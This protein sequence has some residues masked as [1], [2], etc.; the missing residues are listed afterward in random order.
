M[1]TP[2]QP[3]IMDLRCESVTVM[4]ARLRADGVKAALMEAD[5]PWK[6]SGGKNDTRRG[7][8]AQHYGGLSD[9]EIARHLAL[10]GAIAAENAYLAMWITMPK[11]WD[12]FRLDLPPNPTTD[13]I[14]AAANAYPPRCLTDAGWIGLTGAGWG[15][16]KGNGVG[17]HLRGDFEPVLIWKRAGTLPQDKSISSLTLTTETLD[18]W[19]DGCRNLW[20][21]RR[22]GHSEKPQPAL[23]S[24]L[25]MAT[26]PGDTVVNF[27]AGEFASMARAAR[28]MQCH[29]YGA[30]I[31]PARHAA[32][33]ARYSQ[34]EME[35]DG[36][37]KR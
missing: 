16:L 12:F 35:D 18:H 8:A 22:A 5:P 7:L 10:T 34:V 11:L 36:W 25:A 32:S 21:V 15:K 29:Y 23:R 1:I 27:Y 33:L 19:I 17:T 4:A 28:A 24:L 31:D 2:T 26:N 9:L 13:Q 37:P 20:L 30:E 6:Y 3:L 14:V